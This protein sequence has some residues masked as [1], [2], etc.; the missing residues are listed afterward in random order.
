MADLVYHLEIV[1]GPFDGIAGMRWMDDGKH[2]PPELIYV[3]ICV[4]GVNCGSQ[5]CSKRVAH[6]SYWEPHEESR[7]PDGHPYEKQNEFVERAET[8]DGDELVGRAVYAV[9]GLREPKNFG[10]KAREPIPA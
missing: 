4:K 5:Q 9:G 8:S 7:P 2:P 1:G 10:A 3:G 6:P